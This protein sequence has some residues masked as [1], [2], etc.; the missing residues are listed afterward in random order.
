MWLC[1]TFRLCVA[2]QHCCVSIGVDPFKSTAA[3]AGDRQPLCGTWLLYGPIHRVQAVLALT[4]TKGRL[5]LRP[6]GCIRAGPPSLRQ[7][8]SHE[9]LQIA[10]DHASWCPLCMLEG[11]MCLCRK[12]SP[13][14]ALC[15]C[16]QMRHTHLEGSGGSRPC[17]CLCADRACIVLCTSMLHH[18][19]VGVGTELLAFKQNVAFFGVDAR[20]GGSS[21]VLLTHY[22]VLGCCTHHGHVHP[23]PGL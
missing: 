19:A 13:H 12:Q 21:V 4:L 1:G 7:G 17:I 3:F 16:L 14:F 2:V 15:C 22:A 18:G 10:A 20:E 9:A 8:A 6:G 11:V 5:L 23:F